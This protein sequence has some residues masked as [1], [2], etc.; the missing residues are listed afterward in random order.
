MNQF[1]MLLTYLLLLT[2]PPMLLASDN[3]LSIEQEINGYMA[4]NNVPA[5]S[6]GVIK[7]GK[8]TSIKH[9]GVLNRN[10]A[11]PVI[12]NT[13]Y[14]IGSQTKVITSIVT[15]ALINEGK[16]NLTDSVQKLIP[17][18]TSV[19][20]TNAWKSITIEDLLSHRSGLPNYP[21]NVSRKDGEPMIGGYSKEQLAS[22]IRNMDVQENSNKEFSYSNF[23]Y[24][25]LGY[26]LTQ[27]TNKTYQ[28]LIN[29]Y[30][31]D[32]YGLSDIISE[33]PVK[34]RFT[35]ATPYRKDD[36]NT[37][38]Q[39]WDMGLLTPHGGLYA[40]VESLAELM[41]YQLKAYRQK[42]AISPFYSSRVSH[43]TA[44]Y[45][46]LSYGLGMFE[47]TPELGLFSKK[48]YWHGGDLDGYG[49]EYLFSPEKNIGIVMLTSSGGREFVLL[50]RKLMSQLILNNKD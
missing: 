6:I 11:K 48:V 36:R 15:L 50:G 10:T 40:T 26:L 24:A 30:I 28:A 44:L 32:K 12:E 5:L 41:T 49:C 20:K 13:F 43:D 1:K 42:S 17:A 37:E 16:L 29:E 31:T 45:P 23:N 18:Y 34:A 38:T 2:F 46:G 33:S 21:N 47:A 19:S 39:P 22:A 8:V 7:H 35:L 3:K 4:E 27:V 25:L 14:Q 9:F